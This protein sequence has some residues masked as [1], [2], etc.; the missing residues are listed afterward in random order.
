DPAGAAKVATELRQRL[1]QPFLPSLQGVRTVLLSPDGD[2]GR[3]PF[4]AL[5][6]SKP[7]TSLL[8]EY[9]LALVPA[10]QLLPELLQAPAQAPGDPAPLLRLGGVD[11][12]ARPGPPPEKADP[13]TRTAVLGLGQEGAR[14]DPLPGTLP[15]IENVR[16]AFRKRHPDGTVTE[17][18]GGA[19]T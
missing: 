11:F 5:P 14:F 17:L 1:W 19:A 4:A 9:A 15:E 6:G 18:R 13:G 2:V 7:G 12:D 8:E 10:P 16:A 3:F